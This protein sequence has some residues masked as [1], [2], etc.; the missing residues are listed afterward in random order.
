MINPLSWQFHP[1]SKYLLNIT[2]K[3]IVNVITYNIQYLCIFYVYYFIEL[4]IILG[5]FT[6]SHSNYDNLVTFITNKGISGKSKG[7]NPFSSTER[8][9]RNGQDLVAKVSSI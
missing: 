8:L 5:T 3:L 2:Y 4:F 9:V 1:G 6:R 7:W